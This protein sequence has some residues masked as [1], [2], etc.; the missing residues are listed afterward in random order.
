MCQP[1]GIALLNG[2]ENT[3][4][5]TPRNKKEKEKDEHETRLLPR[6][7]RCMLK[8]QTMPAKEKNLPID[9]GEAVQ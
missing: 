1:C 3:D 7:A 5:R 9:D 6:L 2:V 8:T 4:D